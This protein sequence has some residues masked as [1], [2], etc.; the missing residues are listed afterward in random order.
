M[1]QPKI[2]GHGPYVGTTGYS[3][4]TRDFFRGISNHFP[5]KF[6][7]FTVGKSWDGMSDEPHNNE[8]YLTDNDKKILHTQT[9][10]NNKQELED[11]R[12]YTS[13]GEDFNH[14]INLILMETNHHYFYE[15]YKGPKI[16][17]N[18]WE[19][20]LQPEGF[21]NKW[22]EFDQL[23]GSFQWQAQCTIKQGCRS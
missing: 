13:F 7:N 18:V 14:N 16:G 12:M 22:K 5:L 17:Y 21:F 3:N 6:R 9:V 4:H 11:K 2:F 20:T 23:W 1:K 15:N 8:S 10:F 19:S